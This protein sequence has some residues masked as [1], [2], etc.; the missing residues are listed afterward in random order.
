MAPKSICRFKSRIRQLARRNRPGKL[1][2]KIAQLNQFTTGWIAYFRHSRSA[3]ALGD[4]DHW[5]RRKLRV[6]RLKQLKRPYTIAKFLQRQGVPEWS[7][8]LMA[9]SGKGLWRLSRCPQVHQGMNLRWFK[10]IGLVKL[11]GRWK[12]LRIAGP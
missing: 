1:S 6:I 5:I 11:E 12:E 9:L 3:S 10:E 7:S 4:L 2:D 8:W